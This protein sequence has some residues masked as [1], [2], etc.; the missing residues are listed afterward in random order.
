MPLFLKAGGHI[1]VTLETTYESKA[2]TGQAHF[3]SR[4]EGTIRTVDRARGQAH[5]LL[6]PKR[7]RPAPL[8]RAGGPSCLPAHSGNADLLIGE[9]VPSA[10]RR[11]QSG[12]WRSRGISPTAGDGRS[13]S[14]HR[15]IGG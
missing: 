1:P 9:V 4:A 10:R 15:S 12:A 7:F 8:Q 2:R 6:G 11:R 5:W 3:D 14:R 13:A